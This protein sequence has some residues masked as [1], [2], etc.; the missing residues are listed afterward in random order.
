MQKGRSPAV[1]LLDLAPSAFAGIDLLSF[2]TTPR[3]RGIKDLPVG[4]HFIYTGT[5][6]DLSVRH[7]AWIQVRTDQDDRQ[8]LFITRWNAASESFGI[9]L[10]TSEQLRWRANI[11]EFWRDGL[12][13]YRQSAEGDSTDDWASLCSCIRSSLLTR[14]T[15]GDASHWTLTSASSAAVDRDDIPG[16]RAEDFSSA[17]IEELALLPIDLKR[18]WREGAT[19]RERTDAAIDRSWALDNLAKTYTSGSYDDVVGEIQFCF[20][21]TLTL[22]NWSCFEQWKR[23]LTL[24]FTCRAAV[25]PHADFYVRVIAALRL[26][27]QHIKDAEGGLIDMTDEG[28]SLLKDLLAR[29]RRGLIDAPSL[30]QQDV[31]DELDDLEAYLQ[32]EYGWEFGGSFAKSG[33]LDLEDGEQVRMDTTVYDEDDETGEYAPQVVDL[34]PEQARMFDVN[35]PDLLAQMTGTRLEHN[36]RESTAHEADPESE[37]DEVAEDLEDMDQRY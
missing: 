17:G 21:M 23:I 12:T 4:L 5:T 8:P 25:A 27:L 32:A 24:V 10:D 19:G 33:V 20:L 6:N 31:L 34:S 36:A 9:A 30:E 37:L 13:P 22:N 28:Q 7:G 2:T 16:I 18:T 26:Q 14:I 29:F 1:L 11:G 15:G 3:F 35:D